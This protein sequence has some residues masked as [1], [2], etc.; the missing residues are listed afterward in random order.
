MTRDERDV[1][2]QP[3]KTPNMASAVRHQ[4]DDHNGIDEMVVDEEA[5]M[6][7]DEWPVHMRKIVGEH[8]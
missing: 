8:E 3:I 2:G 4:V 7:T 6:I 5:E 1:L